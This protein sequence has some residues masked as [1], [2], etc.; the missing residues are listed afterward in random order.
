MRLRP[1]IF[2]VLTAVLA[3]ALVAIL[4]IQNLVVYPSFVELEREEALK[5]WERCRQA[6][7]REVEHL[8][9][10][11]LDWGSWDD[12]YKF[13]QGQ[14]PT[15]YEANIAKDQWFA[16]Q[17]IDVFYACRPDGTVY[18]GRALDLDALTPVN[19][20]W[21]PPDRL[22]AE[23][24]LL[25]VQ[26]DK[27]SHVSGLVMTE[28]GL[29]MI[30][31]RPILTSQ[32]E[33]PRAG[34][35]IFGRL[36]SEEY[37]AEIRAQTRVD[38]TVIAANDP[39]IPAEAQAAMA[40]VLAGDEPVLE[41]YSR[42]QQ[43]V[44]GVLKDVAGK[45]IAVIQADVPRH[46]TAK[47]NRATLFASI[48]L[49]V[50][51]LVA[52]LVLIVSLRRIVINPLVRL[53]RHATQIAG[54]GDMHRRIQIDRGDEL[55]VLAHEFNQMLVKL[56]DYR[57]QALA[58]S[59]QA[60]MA[61]VTTGVLHNV[62]N[63]VTNANVLAETLVERLAQTKVPTLSR[64]VAVMHE[65]Q[66]DLPQFLSE[67]RKGKQLPAFLEQL[68]AHLNQEMAQTHDDLQALRQGLAHV[69]EIVA[70]QQQF[71]KCTNVNEP[72]DLT[73]V[74][75][76][77]VALI[78]G[79]L[80]R[81]RID[82]RM[83]LEEGLRATCDR[84]KLQQSLVNLLTNAKDAIRDGNSSTREIHIR[85]AHQDEGHVVL[86]V[87]DTGGGIK[88]ENLRRLF[89]NGFTTK[90]DGHG[91]GL[92][93]SALALRQMGG[94]LSASS[95]GPGHGATFTMVLPLETPTPAEITL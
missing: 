48:S 1:K 45:P 28:R 95:D 49:V 59:R 9:A 62:G 19:F 87:R 84:S 20:A 47:G 76:R 33:G 70:A 90:S 82:V 67:D 37:L 79:S 65:H 92:H 40:Q 77:A 93:Y 41:A 36:L 17:R 5:D 63:A 32:W 46:I 61:E 52:L 94:T 4:A 73:D 91:F 31:S 86:W 69:K 6:I 3:A 89:A 83:E 14:M 88:P 56:E 2:L 21:L 44:R 58:M 10:L 53:T 78:Q 43:M 66:A 60:G 23:H 42:Q 25:A 50:A 80:K 55:G 38:F 74:V 11:G 29:M 27:E 81:H 34:V 75:T 64:A 24:P 68:A 85:T 72:V 51:G 26:D 54:S 57:T 18:W 35:L 8:S 7:E 71:A 13:V 22:P 30:V 16:D 12:T 15:Y 39:A